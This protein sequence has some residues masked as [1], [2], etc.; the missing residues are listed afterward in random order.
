LIAAGVRPSRAQLYTLLG[1][2]LLFWSANF[3]FVKLAIRELP[4]VLVVC[5]R[6]VLAGI[7][8]WP[9]YAFA[10]GRFEPGARA[11]S[12]KDAP[13]LVGLGVLGV[14]GNQL[15]FI[16]GL[17]M[18]TVAHG[19]VIAALAPLFVLLGATAIGLE[20]ITPRKLGGMLVAAGGIAV[21]Q[22]GRRE[23]SGSTFAG[24]LIM[25]ASQVVF[26]AFTVF[27]KRVVGT[28]GTITVNAFAFMSG[29]LLVLPFTIWSMSRLDL[30][31]VSS[32]AWLGILYMALF[33]SIAGYLIYS[34]ALRYM[35]ASQ[36]SSVSY[37]QPVLA[38]L[39]AVVF[40]REQPGA[41]FAGGAALVLGGVY[42]TE[43]R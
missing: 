25:I 32:S 3:I 31:R 20:R 11:W 22:L 18:T 29:A 13:A 39:L 23:S 1:A 40:L 24:D 26:A 37:L 17:S 30:A 16:V 4:A 28:F 10:R 34:W 12:L 42:V 7:F 21:L 8:M 36:V 5:I 41:A 9:V 2:M 43:R 14:I 33:P 6:T 38:T 15:L 19:S 35:P 27:G